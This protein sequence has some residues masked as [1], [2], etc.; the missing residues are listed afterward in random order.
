MSGENQN[1]KTFISQLRSLRL[2]SEE[3]KWSTDNSSFWKDMMESQQR[4]E[5]IIELLPDATL[6]I[7]LQGE[8]VFWNKALQEM[9]GVAK[10]Q[11]IGRGNYEYAIP[12]YGERRPILIDIALNEEKEKELQG[13]YDFIGRD[14]QTLSGEVNVPKTYSGK[15]AYLWGYASKLYDQQGNLYGAIQSIRDISDRK[16]AEENLRLAEERF[17]KAFMASPIPL[18]IST[19]S[20]GIYLDVNDAF[21]QAT[22]YLREEVI[23]HSWRDLDL[24]PDT[25]QRDQLSQ[26]LRNGERLRNLEIRFSTKSRQE[27]LA[28]ISLERI[29]IS[30]EDC[31]VIIF[32]D[33]TEKK[34]MEKDIARL[35]RLNLIGQMA[36]SIGHEIR[37]PMTAV[38]GFI[39]MLNEQ[40]CY[41]K[42]QPFFEVMIEELDR[43]NGIISEYLSM[44]NNKIVNLRPQ[45]LD[46]VVKA[47]SP[48]IEANAI[49]KGINVRLN[50]S[51]PPMPIIDD[52]EIRQ[53]ILNL[54]NNGIEAMAE[55]GT[56]TIGTAQTDQEIILYVK[57][58][59]SGLDAEVIE[60]LG[61]PFLTTKD[62]GTGLGLAVCYSIAA[63]H[64]ARIDFETG[65]D[66]TTF[67]ILFP[68][69]PE[70][71][72]EAENRAL[73]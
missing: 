15:G 28:Q 8:V 71:D 17:G 32:I 57:D 22:G 43:A 41:A 61:T 13:K 21:L 37:N 49:Y 11:M 55:G 60:K 40:E 70:I 20:E 52:K 47:I 30:G 5:Q 3:G 73:A 72:I 14:E 64:H 10:E 4:L 35:D 51:K 58:Q 18:S 36:A 12:F 23:G 45:Y 66:G 7:N 24:W 1:I 31:A 63:R 48:I 44:A 19:L 50:L 25:N 27:R 9:T 69:P 67:K 65:D 54:S 59:G 68:I 29:E 16:K 38:R 34:E 33:I 53:M 42:D 39:Q 6:V 26:R 62:Q 46:Q 2:L 56:L